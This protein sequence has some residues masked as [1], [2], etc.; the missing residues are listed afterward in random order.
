MQS[1]GSA[2]LV[3]QSGDGL[4]T[5]DLGGHVDHLAGVVQGRAQRT[6]LMWAMIVEVSF[7]LSQD[8]ARV[9]LTID[10]QV[11]EALAA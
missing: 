10:Q 6:T 2:V 4:S 7:I 8:H 5:V 1:G 9:P 11:I 3:G